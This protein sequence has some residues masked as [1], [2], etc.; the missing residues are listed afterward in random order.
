MFEKVSEAV[1]YI[2]T[3]TGIIPETG[4]VLGTGLGNLAN[5]IESPVFI[6]YDEIP[7]FPSSTVEGHAGRL[8]IGGL[9]GCRVVAMQ[10]RFHFYEGYDLQDVVFP[11]R[12]MKFLGINLL[13]LSNASGG[14]NPG[15][16]VGDIMIV[17]DHINLMNLMNE[18]PLK[19]VHDE[20][21]GARFPDMSRPY[22]AG[23]IKKAEILAEK[24]GIHYRKGIYAG[25]TG[26]T[27]ETPAE[28]S[29]IRYLG[30]DAVGMSTV[31]EAIAAAQ[32]QLPVFAVS[33]IADLGVKGKIVE[34]SH[35]EVIDAA[36]LAEPLMTRLIKALLG[37]LFP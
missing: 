2:R 28:Y 19:G 4:I 3:R 9:N 30:A 34:I 12:V 37:E 29:Y 5:E 21:F 11:I 14:L 6:P 23:L 35:K 25:V 10:G 32:L 1:D 13:I 26:P 8:I 31:P 7:H 22:D 18:N 36:S 24:M 20:R 15:F 17:E 27:F 16:Q 33:V